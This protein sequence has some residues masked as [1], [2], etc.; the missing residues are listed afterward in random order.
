MAV[1][2]K[3]VAKETNLAISTISKYINGGNVREKNR[4]KIQMAIEKLG[5]VPNDAAR[6]LRTFRTYMVGLITGGGTNQHTATIISETEKQLRNLGYSLTSISLGPLGQ[7]SDENKI[8]QYVDYLIDRGVDGLII[9]PLKKDI[10]YLESARLRNIPVVLIEEREVVGNTNIYSVLA[11][12]AGGAYEIVEHLV[13]KGHKKIGIIKGP[14][15]KL[16]AM[17]R[18]TGYKRVMED[19]GIPIRKEYMVEGD[20]TYKGGYNGILKLCSL[21]DRPTAVFATNYDTCLGALEAIRNLGMKIPEDISLVTFDDYD[22]SV[23]LRP[24]LTAVRQP[25]AKMAE[26]ASRLLY[27]RMNGEDTVFPTI[28]RLK[29]ECFF[30]DSVKDLYAENKEAE[31]CQLP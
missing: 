7:E 9:A 15:Y 1:T 24:H 25:L 30:R 22:L 16:T 29:T 3:D 28:V 11:D 18:W 2:I 23:V 31:L 20:Y 19:Y 12:C 27:K 17:E 4:K 14:S 10:D 6:G 21:K 8:K 5:F 26:T 13:K